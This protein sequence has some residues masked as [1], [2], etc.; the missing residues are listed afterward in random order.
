[1]RLNRRK[2]VEGGT[3]EPQLVSG[4]FLSDFFRVL[5]GQ[6]IAASELLGDLPIPIGERGQVR[7]AVDWNLFAELMKRLE[8]RVGGPAGLEVCGELIGEMAPAA[9]LRGLAGATASPYLLYYAASQWALRRALPGVSARLS[10]EGDGQLTIVARIADDLRPCPQIFHFAAGGARILPRLIGLDDAV[11]SASIEDREARY[12]ITIPP[13]RSLIARFRRLFRTIFSAGSILHFLEAQ[14][15]ELHAKNDALQQAHDA[16][17]ASE[18]R[19]RAITDAAVD[20]LCEIDARGVI[21]YVSASVH[22]LMGYSPEQV[23]N[24]HYRLWLAREFHSD[25]DRTFDRLLVMP[26]G[27]AVQEVVQLHTDRGHPIDVELTARS[28]QAPD[29]G[30]RIVCIL[31]DL[32]DRAPVTVARGRPAQ[33]HVDDAREGLRAHLSHEVTDPHSTPA[34]ER[35][36]G[37]LLVR[38]DERADAANAGAGD[39]LADATNRITRVIDASLAHAE[40]GSADLQWI[41]AQKLLRRVQDTFRTLRGNPTRGLHIDLS[42]APGEIWGSEVLLETALLS[43]LDW[44]FE[45]SADSSVDEPGRA[46]T[47]RAEASADPTHVNHLVLSVHAPDMLRGSA[48]PDPPS[49]DTSIGALALAI[50]GD[51]TEALGGRLV[52]SEDE[53]GICQRIQLAQPPNPRRNG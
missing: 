6:G 5:E 25:V 20:V 37:Q 18:R 32:S 7:M 52:Q 14:Q 1:M 26:E 23:T 16:L 40:G 19:Y 17:A 15:L 28:Y 13:S 35:S 39:V 22:D 38:L 29:G 46:I 47:L 43:L 12:Q 30:R 21:V 2:I 3:E 44:A 31:R 49:Q 51:A 50:A 41:E 42:S 11:V 10:R 8:N 53:G 45:R 34:L 24:S 36:L 48:E 33:L 9:A 27:R 4:R